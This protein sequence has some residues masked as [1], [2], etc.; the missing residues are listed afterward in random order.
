MFLRRAAR[1]WLLAGLMIILAGAAQSAAALELL[2]FQ[3][4]IVTVDG[5]K[6][7]DLQDLAEI[8]AV[9]S[10]VGRLYFGERMLLAEDLL[11]KYI[12]NYYKEYVSEALRVDQKEQRNSVRQDWRIVVR[13]RKLQER[14]AT[15][16]FTYEPRYQ[17]YYAVFFQ[18]QE[19]GA[20]LR[21]P[22]GRQIVIEKFD[23]Q[24]LNRVRKDDFQ[25]AIPW[26]TDYFSLNEGQ[27]KNLRIAM[28]KS[29]IEVLVTGKI[30]LEDGGTQSFYLVDDFFYFDASIELSVIRVSDDS[31]LYTIKDSYKATGRSQ[32]ET[33]DKAVEQLTSKVAE[34]AAERFNPAW[35]LAYLDTAD[36]QV[37]ITGVDQQ[38]VKIIEDQIRS[39]AGTEWTNDAGDTELVLPEVYLRGFYEDVVVLSVV[40]KGEQQNLINSL[41][42][43]QYPRLVLQEHDDRQ[44]ILEQVK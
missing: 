41:A 1:R 38:D 28:M 14:M 2:D 21:N 23:N 9:R 3:T 39:L 42:S 26:E 40:Y 18:Q 16:R 43:M 15:L 36:Y 17:P 27:R 10:C 11:D 34:K 13:F 33:T 35:Q 20:G 25:R 7:T 32:T 22:E 19:N 29:G 8:K 6:G 30:N 31:V 4:L 44:V 37:M 24:F 5:P 12:E